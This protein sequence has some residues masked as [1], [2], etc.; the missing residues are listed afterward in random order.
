MEPSE[1]FV[2]APDFDS[3]GTFTKLYYI[4]FYLNIYYVQSDFYFQDYCKGDETSPE[5]EKSFCYSKK[6]K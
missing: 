5:I 4:I 1:F 3:A 6:I 2:G